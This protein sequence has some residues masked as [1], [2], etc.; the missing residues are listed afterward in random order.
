M[1]PSEH[2]SSNDPP[3]VQE[4]QVTQPESPIINQRNLQIETRTH[5]KIP[6]STFSISTSNSNSNL[7]SSTDSPSPSPSHSHSHSHSR[8]SINSINNINNNN[9]NNNRKSRTFTLD[10]SGSMHSQQDQLRHGHLRSLSIASTTSSGSSTVCTPSSSSAKKTGINLGLSFTGVVP[11][12]TSSVSSNSLSNRLSSQ[13]NQPLG[14]D[15]SLELGSSSASSST[16]ADNFP[17]PVT[18]IRRDSCATN[19]AAT[20]GANNNT[21]TGL[22]MALAGV[23]SSSSSGGTTATNNRDSLSTTN[24]SITSRSGSCSGPQLVANDIRASTIE[25]S[26]A[27]K[28]FGNHS[29]TA[30]SSATTLKFENEASVLSDHLRILASKEMEILEIK[31]EID[32]LNGRKKVLEFELQDLK[33]KVEQQLVRQ[34]TQQNLAA[35]NKL[36]LSYLTISRT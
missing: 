1:S 22:D 30:P 6:N 27:S 3:S 35:N 26:T 21:M 16:A 5:H 7:P 25:P 11:G 34:L 8:N 4:D 36:C 20:S 12:L 31:Q 33:I 28:T 32:N 23:T 17:E 13:F 19:M 14:I 15:E 29:R 24:S 9:N 18:P 2:P 10:S